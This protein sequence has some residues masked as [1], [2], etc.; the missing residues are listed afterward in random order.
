L[1][2]TWR[3]KSPYATGVIYDAFEDKIFYLFFCPTLKLLL[4][5]LVK[6]REL[7]LNGLNIAH[8]PFNGMT[9]ETRIFVSACINGKIGRLVYVSQIQCLF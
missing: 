7:V 4:F 8:F 3:E 2:K 1:S 5:L 9:G 6:G